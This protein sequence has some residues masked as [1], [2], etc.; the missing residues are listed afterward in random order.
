MPTAKQLFHPSEL[1]LTPLTLFWTKGLVRVFAISS[2]APASHGSRYAIRIVQVATQG[3][4]GQAAKSDMREVV[5]RE[6]GNKIC[7]LTFQKKHN[8][9]GLP[10]RRTCVDIAVTVHSVKLLHFARVQACMKSS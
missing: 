5:S 1:E 6:T 2:N 9:W 8:P 7:H 4:I 10:R 3:C